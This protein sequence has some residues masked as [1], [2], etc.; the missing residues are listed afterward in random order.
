MPDDANISPTIRLVEQYR[1][2]L[3]NAFDFEVQHD[4]ESI[5]KSGVKYPPLPVRDVLKEIRRTRNEWEQWR[6]LPRAVWFFCLSVWVFFNHEDFV[7]T[8]NCQV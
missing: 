7:S 8:G 2:R 4:L 3:S 1:R 6:E 5:H